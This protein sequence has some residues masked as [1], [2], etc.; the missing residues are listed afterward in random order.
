MI[1]RFFILLLSLLLLLSC[2]EN[3]SNESNQKVSEIKEEESKTVPVEALELKEKM[4]NQNFPVTGILEPNNS[5]DI[6]A[7]VS[8]KV[9]NIYKELGDYVKLNQTMAVIDDVILKSQYDQAKAQ[10]LST[11]NNL[12]I[13]K[14]NF[15]SDKILFDN[16]DIS[17][18]E[19]NSSQLAYSN[20]EAQYLSALAA[21]SAAKKSY[22]DT[23]IKSP[24][25][26]FIS[27]NNINY[28]SMVLA[29]Q[30][31]YRV[32][33]LSKL[34][35]N[36]SVPQ[37]IINRV[38]SGNKAEI[39]ITALNNKLFNGTIKR[40]SPEADESTGG[41]NVEV[42][43]TNE[44]N[45][46]K[47]GMTSKVD[48]LLSKEQNVLAIPEYALVQKNEHNYVYKIVNSFAELIKV[49]LGET[50]G[51]KIIVESGLESGDKIVVV[52]MK[53]LGVKTKVRIEKLN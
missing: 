16:E 13:T 40:I 29:G 51:D 36:L 52:G 1:Y 14:D 5:V 27:K 3:S 45:I 47:A 35:L 23:R 20:A 34:K 37:E 42:E 7:E 6:I 24:I 22:D 10:V 38:K 9:T 30:N 19:F 15:N 8:G 25:S 2:G 33:N 50:I 32:V 12:K 18:F 31:L 28:G 39:K 46:I 49:E 11:K 26:G 21:L 17:E 44:K 48:L 41:F 43:V 53:N 4:I